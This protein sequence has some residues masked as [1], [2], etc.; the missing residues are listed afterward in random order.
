MYAVIEVIVG[1]DRNNEDDE[2]VVDTA[3]VYNDDHL[4]VGNSRRKSCVIDCA[5]RNQ[6]QSK[7]VEAQH[8]NN[9]EATDD[10]DEATDNDDEATDDDDE[11]TD[12]DDDDVDFRTIYNA[13]FLRGKQEWVPQTQKQFLVQQR[14]DEAEATVI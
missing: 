8:P 7:V 9:D 14:M 6:E 11:V 5:Q 13:K 12:D 2:A 3:C 4:E 1:G 10:D